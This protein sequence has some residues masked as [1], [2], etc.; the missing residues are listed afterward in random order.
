MA[1]D[2]RFPMRTLLISELLASYRAGRFTPEQVIEAVLAQIEAAPERNVW[3]TRLSRA[4]VMRYVEG[5]RSRP[6]DEQP[7]Y[8]VPFAIKDNIDLAGTPTTAACA[9]YA[10]VP[11]QSATV[12]RRLIA[13]GA[14]PIGKTNLDQFA[15]GLVGTR[16]P[17]GACANSLDAQ[18]ISGGSSSG[19]AVAV[20]GALVSFALGTDTAGSGRVPAAFNNI[21][22]LKP[23]CGLLSTSGVVPACRSLDTVSIFAMT[24]QDAQRVLAVA[25][26]FDASDAYSRDFSRLP[27]GRVRPRDGVRIGIPRRGQL[28]FFGDDG[29]E[30]CFDAVLGRLTSLGWSC[31]EVDFEPFLAAARLLYEGPWIAERYAALAEFM[32]A[33]ADAMHPVT[34][35]IISSGRA[36]SAADAFRAQ[37]RLK[38]LQRAC[39]PVWHEIDLLLTPTAGSIYTIAQVLADPQRLNANLGYYTNFVNLLDLAAIAVPGGVRADGLPFGVTLIAPSGSDSMLLQYGAQLHAAC[40][41]VLGATSEH[42]PA[43]ASGPQQIQEGFIGLV[44]CGA[45]LSGLPLNHQLQDRDAYL[46]RRSRTASTY[47]FYALPG[48]PPQR[49]GL[50]RVREGGA[51][52]EVELWA[53]PHQHLGSLV[54]SI[55]APLGIGKIE[56]EDGSWHSGF[57]CEAHALESALDI[58]PLRGWWSYLAQAGKA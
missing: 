8:G 47:K 6:I 4:E 26:G 44:V 13:A 51:A 9:Q 12:V 41:K 45:H 40:A 15:T 17:Y 56:L 58:T 35:S 24:A 5:L 10:Y 16:S 53:V 46:V 19:S 1:I 23:S 2:Q 43:P 38:E 52:I 57:L 18:Y 54:A 11:Q 20:A 48:G 30:Q 28:C 21:V 50:V 33:H 7:L 37:Y 49:P 22:G 42:V 36:M 31:V 14:I 27:V 3:V 32:D 39:E 29:Y 25:R 34:R 55:P